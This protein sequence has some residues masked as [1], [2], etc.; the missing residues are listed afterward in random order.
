[1]KIALITPYFHPVEGGRERTVLYLAEGLVK[2][3]HT[4]TVFASDR[5]PSGGRVRIKDENWD[6]SVLINII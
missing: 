2:R 4:V 3:G 5:T 1:M 6:F